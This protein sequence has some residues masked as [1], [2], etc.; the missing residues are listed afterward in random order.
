MNRYI[1]DALF[2]AVG[3]IAGTLVIQKMIAGLSK[4][5]SAED[6]TR[7]QQLVPEQPLQKLARRISEN[8]LGVEIDTE[9]KA[10]MGQAISWGYGTFWGAVYGILRKRVPAASWGGGLPFGVGLTIFGEGLM[11]PLLDLSPPAHRF[12][13]SVIGRDIVS[14]CAYAATVEGICRACEATEQ[15]GTRQPMRTKPELRKVS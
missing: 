10:T 9:T 12:P 13:L 4:L 3:G 2:G 1:K 14:H 8:V 7:E 6:K 15:A 11:L 5:Q